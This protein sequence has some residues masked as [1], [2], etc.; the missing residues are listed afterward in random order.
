MVIDLP[1]LPY[2]TYRG[3]M[4]HLMMWFDR[5]KHIISQLL[6]YTTDIIMMND[7]AIMMMKAHGSQP[8]YIYI[9]I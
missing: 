6:E 5:G 7:A 9:Y 4:A 8:R 2:P 3:E 1:Y